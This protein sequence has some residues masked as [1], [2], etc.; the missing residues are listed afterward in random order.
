MGLQSWLAVFPTA[1]AW[2]QVGEHFL[3][4]PAHLLS[5]G[6]EQRAPS[7]PGG[8]NSASPPVATGE[9]GAEADVFKIEF[10][11]LS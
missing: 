11:D 8:C 7:N 5:L 10:V 4:A 6:C 1:A 2:P 3:L 9:A